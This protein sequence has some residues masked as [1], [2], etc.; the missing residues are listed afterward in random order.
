MKFCSKCGSQINDET[1]RFCL[2]CGTALQTT[3][4]NNVGYGY[5]IPA[6]P[7]Y[8]MKWFKF[9]IY[10]ALFFGAFLE[11]CF[12]ISY[13]TGSIYF[14]QTN[15]Q[16]SAEMVYGMYGAPL[17]ILD[18]LYG[19]VTLGAAVF[20]IVTRF[21]LAK[22]KA[23][24]PKCLYILYIVGGLAGLVYNIG[25]SMI[26]GV[27]GIFNSS[28]ISSIVATAIVVWANYKYFSKRDEL[29]NN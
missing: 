8:P 23:N 6:K 9:L 24:G 2:K 18:V 4:G 28:F 26:T 14:S 15:G 12:A 5:S 22:F 10:F 13:F 20:S 25:V 27:S 19:V 17:K 29:F 16:V 11:F 21:R 3:E 7:E 1:Q